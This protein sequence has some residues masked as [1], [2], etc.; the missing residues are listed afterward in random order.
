MRVASEE[1]REFIIQAYS[2]NIRPDVI[3]RVAGVDARYVHGLAYKQGLREVRDL[4]QRDEAM[5]LAELLGVGEALRAQRAR[6]GLRVGD[7][8]ERRR[9]SRP[10]ERER[11]CDGRVSSGGRPE[12]RVRGVM[13]LMGGFRDRN[14]DPESGEDAA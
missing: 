11:R 5:E 8:V 2:M 4:R 14:C 13:L 3:A 9:E 1:V 12:V 6:A 10:V 7:C